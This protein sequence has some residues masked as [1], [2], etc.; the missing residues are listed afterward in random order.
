MQR[1]S[2][3]ATSLQGSETNEHKIDRLHAIVDLLLDQVLVRGFHGVAMVKI[4]VQ[5]GTIQAIEDGI[6][7]KHR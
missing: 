6:E 4:S 1:C 3:P 7:K 5:D 2:V